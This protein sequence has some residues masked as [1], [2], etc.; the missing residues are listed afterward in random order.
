MKSKSTNFLMW[1]KK[2]LACKNYLASI[3]VV[4][5]KVCI[6]L[7]CII[8]GWWDYCV[9]RP[10]FSLLTNIHICCLKSPLLTIVNIAGQPISWALLAPGISPIT[11]V[12]GV[13]EPVLSSPSIRLYKYS[14]YDGKVENKQTWYQVNFSTFLHPIHT[15][16][17]SNFH[18]SAVNGGD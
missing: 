15:N 12:E 13:R 5:K 1:L 6:P 11:R 14:I 9:S 8:P 18:S 4:E 3:A 16:G 7:F 17:F 2:S 10:I